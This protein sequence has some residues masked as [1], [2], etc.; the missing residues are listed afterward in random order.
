VLHESD[1]P[2]SLREVIVPGKIVTPVTDLS[3]SAD[4]RQ[5]VETIVT[6]DPKGIRVQIKT[7][8]GRE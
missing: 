1:G 7:W 5:I 2:Y 4:G 3:F 8:E 6:S